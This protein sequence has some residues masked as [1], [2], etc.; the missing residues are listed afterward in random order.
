MTAS[1]EA[2]S[3]RSVKGGRWT[4]EWTTVVATAETLGALAKSEGSVISS[5]ARSLDHVLRVLLGQDKAK[6]NIAKIHSLCT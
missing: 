5:D 6:R 1:A 3:T 2:V 4:Q